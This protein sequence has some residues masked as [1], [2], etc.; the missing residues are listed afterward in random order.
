YMLEGTRE[1]GAAK[2][3]AVRLTGM[4]FGAYPM[5][6]GL[7]RLASRFLD[8]PARVDELR[9]RIGEE[10]EARA[11]GGG[12]A[13]R[14]APAALRA[15]GRAGAAFAPDALAGMEASLRF[16]GP[17]TLESKIF[18]RLSA[19]QNWI[20]QRPNAVGDKGALRVYGTGQRS[21]FDRRR[22]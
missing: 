22:T 13:R 2:P 15:E 3:A 19:W 8:E 5:V 17:E 7:N 4:N 9:R 16:G 21:E 14:L 20:F 6:N 18:S 12:G 10:L 1:G 11:A